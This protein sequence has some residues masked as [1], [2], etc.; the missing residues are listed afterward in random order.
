MERD[1]EPG[2]MRPCR[3]QQVDNLFEW[4][5]EFAG[6]VVDRPALRQCEPHEKP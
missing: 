6:E 5:A 2:G 3:A 1:A 4:R